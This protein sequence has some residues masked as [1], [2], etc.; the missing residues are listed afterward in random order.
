MNFAS[1]HASRRWMSLLRSDAPSVH[2]KFERQLRD[3]RLSEWEPGRGTYEE[4]TRLLV[5]IAIWSLP[6]LELLDYLDESLKNLPLQCSKK[7]RIDVC[8]LEAVQ[9]SMVP[10]LY[11]PGFEV[12]STPV[13]GLWEHGLHKVTRPGD[14][15]AREVLKRLTRLDE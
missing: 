1:I 4:G 11:F 14:L 3:S 8:V 13:V 5:C 12:S 15:L 9:Q 6:D 10:H 2:A 7:V